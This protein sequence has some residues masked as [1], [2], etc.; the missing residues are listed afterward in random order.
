MKQRYGYAIIFTQGPR[1]RDF[2]KGSTWKQILA[3]CRRRPGIMYQLAGS[4]LSGKM[5]TTKH[6]HCLPANDEYVMDFGFKNVNL[7]RTDVFDRRTNNTNGWVYF[8]S[9]LVPDWDQYKEIQC[10][11]FYATW[12]RLLMWATRGRYQCKNCTTVTRHWLHCMGIPVPR[13]CWNPKLLLLWMT[14]NGYSFTYGD[15]TSD[16]GT[17]DPGAG[18]A[19]PDSDD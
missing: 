17:A 12:G 2:L 13:K 3:L 7:V 16:V 11:L 5:T 15:H 19:A 1:L 8:E 9:S 6:R 18:R 14:E 10:S 4:W